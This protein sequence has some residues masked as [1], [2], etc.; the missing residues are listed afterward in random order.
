MA[1]G[2][3]CIHCI[4]NSTSNPIDLTRF[5]KA[6][7]A[8]QELLHIQSILVGA[9]LGKSVD[10]PQVGIMSSAR[11]LGGLRHC[12]TAIGYLLDLGIEVGAGVES[13][14]KAP[15]GLLF[16]PKHK[17]SLEF[18]P[19]A[20]RYKR[21]LWIG[22]FFE[23]P[24]DRWHIMLNMPSAPRDL[25][26]RTR[27]PWELIGD[28]GEPLERSTAIGKSYHRHGENPVTTVHRF[29][30]VTSFLTLTHDVI[31]SVLGGISL[32]KYESWRRLPSLSIPASC[33]RRMEHF[34]RIWDG[35]V[36]LFSTEEQARRWMLTRNNHSMMEGLPPVYFLARDPDGSRFVFVSDLI[37]RKT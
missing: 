4:E 24:L 18:L 12:L 36:D 14:I 29:F 21:T 11:F 1:K 34:L 37:G 23:A 17:L 33:H 22:W 26:K 35:V 10:V 27:H 31:R 15:P 30:K 25:K 6:Q 13:L 16:K 32:K 20:E 8:S 9:F 2:K 3:L 7:L 19:L 5:P 28:H